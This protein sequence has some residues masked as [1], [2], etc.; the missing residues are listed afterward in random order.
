MVIYH[1]LNI[2]PF[3]FFHIYENSDEFGVS[4]NYRRK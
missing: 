4:Q 2:D 1:W 3:L